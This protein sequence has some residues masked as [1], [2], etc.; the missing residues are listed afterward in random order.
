MIPTH[1]TP[2]N[3]GE[4]RIGWASWDN[5]RYKDRSIKW[6]YPDRSGKVSRGAP[7]ISFEVLVDMFLLAYS[8]GE[9][10]E[11]FKIDP[12]NNP[13]L[14]APVYGMHVDALRDERK[15]L[16]FNQVILQKLMADLPWIDWKNAHNAIE[17]RK[18]DVDAA[19]QQSAPVA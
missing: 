19:L 16:S 6:A 3:D 17:A 11:L 13:G 4:L 1:V 12:R 14:P 8:E 18:N 7:E 2:Y 10:D 15:R 9:L 5:G